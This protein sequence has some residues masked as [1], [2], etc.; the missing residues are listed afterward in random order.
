MGNFPY[1]YGMAGTKRIQHFIDAVYAEHNAIMVLLLRQ[2]GKAIK[3]EQIIEKGTHKGVPFQ[4]IGKGL[5]LNLSLPFKYVKYLRDG[6][7]ILNNF[8]KGNRCI[9]YYYGSINLDNI[10]FIL[11]GYLKGYKIVF[12]IVED[13]DFHSGKVSLAR[14]INL[15]IV[16]FLDRLNL[17]L[18]HA[19]VVISTHLKKKYVKKN[20]YNK[21]I[22]LIPI[23]AKIEQLPKKTQFNDP[24]RITY[25]GSFA[26]KDGLDFLIEAVENIDPR[27][28]VVLNLIGRGRQAD[29]Y[30]K[31][32]GHLART[33]FLGY[34]P[35][36]L[37]YQELLNADI[38]C[39][40]RT[41]SGFSHAGF[42]FKLGEYLATGN[43]VIT[44]HTGD[45]SHY[46]KDKE[47]ALIVEPGSATALNEAIERLLAKPDFALQI[48]R[49]GREACI[50]HFNVSKNNAILLNLLSEIVK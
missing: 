29:Y 26:A 38:L 7:N 48:G 10:V 3:Q 37:F 32:Y 27:F 11:Y 45:V 44:S 34:L 28:N 1:P 43:P 18:G 8:K 30:K 42:P 35:D 21:P 25:A 15:S 41:G 4:T 20:K 9:I 14:R 17:K 36:D 22:V 23:S 47:N 39:V 49:K 40:P 24:I 2:G 33:N 13:Y 50:Q 5:K 19:I 31:K 46:L 16:R 12:D 6:L